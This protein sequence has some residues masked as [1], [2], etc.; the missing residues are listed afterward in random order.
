MKPGFFD[1]I[2]NAD[3]HGGVGVSSSGVK[4]VGVTPAHYYAAYLDPEREPVEQTPA[5]AFGTACHTIILEPEDYATRHLVI[6]EGVSR[7]SKD[8]KAE[9]DALEEAAAAVGGTTIKA[10]DD[11]LVRKIGD[12]M[13]RSAQW[14]RLHNVGLAERSYY[15]IDEET[16]VL[17]KCRPDWQTWV[18]D[19]PSTEDLI[20]DV[21]TAFA[22]DPDAFERSAYNLGYHISAAFYLDG[23]EAVTGVRPA[24]FVFACVEKEA[25]FATAFYM[26]DG[27]MIREGRAVYRRN[28]RTLATCLETGKWPGYPDAIQHIG[29][30]KWAKVTG[31]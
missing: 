4:K 19:A 30:P 25:P 24:G 9:L 16:G 5:M 11:V 12:A 13:Q 6:P 23:V 26:A 1:G 14:N 2:P 17:C 21:K 15:W 27:G 22:A 20:V 18:T 8:G 31:V 3:Y 28:L 29:L 7:R 10:E